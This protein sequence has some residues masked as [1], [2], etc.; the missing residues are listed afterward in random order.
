METGEAQTQQHIP[1]FVRF[2]YSIDPQSISKIILSLLSV[3]RVKRGE[4]TH[5]LTREITGS[6]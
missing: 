5:N 3:F 6:L 4:M 1:E 2:V